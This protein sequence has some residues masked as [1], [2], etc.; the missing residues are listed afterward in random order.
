MRAGNGGKISATEVRRVRR[1]YCRNTTGELVLSAFPISIR[2]RFIDNAGEIKLLLCM[3]QRGQLVT[4]VSVASFLRL[5]YAC[6]I[7]ALN[8]FEV[9]AKLTLAKPV[10]WAPYEEV[11]TL[12]TRTQFLV[13]ISSATLIAS[14]VIGKNSPM[15]EAMRR[16]DRTHGVA[17]GK[18]WAGCDFVVGE[19]SELVFALRAH[20]L[21]VMIILRLSLHIHCTARRPDLINFTRA[22]V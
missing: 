20:A 2:T 4:V 6:D 19:R 11:P 1:C 21:T 22:H 8:A 7:G 17:K 15:S 18:N 14:F 16:A 9:M 3:E 10:A 13:D 12:A 5:L